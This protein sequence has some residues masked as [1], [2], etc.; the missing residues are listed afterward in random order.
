MAI[1]DEQTKSEEKLL[2]EKPNR[3]EWNWGPNMTKKHRDHI[4]ANPYS[5]DECGDTYNKDDLCIIQYE[6]YIC[7]NCQ[8][9]G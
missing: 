8:C 4:N 9:S 2:H 5:C 6:I 3:F 1:N 7:K